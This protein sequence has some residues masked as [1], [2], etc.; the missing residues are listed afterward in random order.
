M[1]CDLYVDK[2]YDKYLNKDIYVVSTTDMLPRTFCA[3]FLDFTNRK[4]L[5]NEVDLLLRKP[6][7]ITVSISPEIKITIRKD[8]YHVVVSKELLDVFD[9]LTNKENIPSEIKDNIKKFIPEYGK[10]F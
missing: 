5:N 8:Q 9:I 7:D 6:I 2:N 10:L 3:K 1:N 4:K